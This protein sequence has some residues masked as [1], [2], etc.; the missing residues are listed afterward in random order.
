VGTARLWQRKSLYSGLDAVTDYHD[1]TGLAFG[2]PP[3]ASPHVTVLRTR[4]QVWAWWASNAVP[5]PGPAQAAQ[6]LMAKV[7]Y[8]WAETGSYP[9]PAGWPADPGVDGPEYAQPT[10]YSALELRAQTYRPADPAAMTPQV[11]Y[12]WS[13]LGV[14]QGD[15]QA[16]RRFDDTYVISAW[17]A[18]AQQLYDWG[19][20]GG[21]FTPIPFYFRYVLNT[22]LEYPTA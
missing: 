8:A 13:E 3:S 22:L 18:I 19:T 11:F 6:P 14:L 20:A 4:L 16:R 7:Q 1:D 12:G 15:S 2:T 21:G 9:A 17:V 5:Y 10:V